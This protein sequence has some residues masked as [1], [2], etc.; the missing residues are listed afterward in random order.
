MTSPLFE[1]EAVRHGYGNAF[2]LDVPRLVLEEGAS[3]GLVGPN[4]SGKSTLLRILALIEEPREGIVRFCGAAVGS[5]TRHGE[6]GRRGADRSH[7][8]RDVAILLQ[9]PYLLKKTVFDNVAFGL[10]V[11]GEREGLSARV[12]EALESVGLPPGRFAKRRWHELSGGE[13]HRVALAARLAVRPKVLILDEPTASV[14]RQSARLIKE[15]V[16]EA[17]RRH[18][19]ALIISSHDQVWLSGVAGETLKMYDGRIVEHGAPNILCGPWRPGEDGLSRMALKDGQAITAVD[20]PRPDAAAL[21]DPTSIIL[22]TSRPRGISAQNALGGTIAS[23]TAEGKTIRVEIDVSGL[24]LHCTITP[25]AAE[26]LKILP[27]RRVYV[28]FKASSLH[29]Y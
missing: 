3:V 23:M 19:T 21:L 22:T 17:G 11:R 1:L 10:K 12:G 14:D 5:E 2:T 4:G 24:P 27:G 18:G 8:R 6:D 26:S 28:V 13:S 7:L 16:A 9:D 29:W 25:P 20:P 15:A